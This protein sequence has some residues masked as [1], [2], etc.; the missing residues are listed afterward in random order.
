MAAR[1]AVLDRLQ[2]QLAESLAQAGVPF[3][4][5]NL[6]TSARVAGQHKELAGLPDI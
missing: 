3:K 5:L 1:E 6:R 2:W 4:S